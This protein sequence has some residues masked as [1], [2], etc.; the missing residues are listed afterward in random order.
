[1]SAAGLTGTPPSWPSLYNPG[2]ELLHIVHHDPVQPDGAYLSHPFDIFRF[3]L[4]WT[5]IFYTP[6]FLCCGSTPSSTSR[7]L[8]P[9][10]AEA[11]A[12]RYQSG[13]LAHDVRPPCAPRVPLTER[14]RHAPQLRNHRVYPRGWIPFLWALISVPVGILSVWPS[15]IDII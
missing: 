14:R 1:M 9:R 12:H 6:I 2:I 7:S 5:L 11:E 13:A 10:R 15:V 8:R 3:T 4:Y